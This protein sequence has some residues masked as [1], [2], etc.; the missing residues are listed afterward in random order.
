[1]KN[2]SI[3]SKGNA[4][5]ES[6]CENDLIVKGSQFIDKNSCKQKMLQLSYMQDSINELNKP[7]GRPSPRMIG[8]LSSAGFLF[9]YPVIYSFF[10]GGDISPAN[11]LFA[12]AANTLF[13]VLA[14]RQALCLPGNYAE[15]FIKQLKYYRPINRHSY[16]ALLHGININNGKINLL[17]SINWIKEEVDCLNDNINY[18]RSINP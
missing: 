12:I 16:D 5:D 7:S 6:Q 3:S 13:L 10:S 4:S 8:L 14:T 18:P 15:L 1:M 2:D 11:S 17:D 9:P